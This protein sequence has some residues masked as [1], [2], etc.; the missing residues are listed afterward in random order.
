M[1]KGRRKLC[2]VRWAV[3]S[4]CIKNKWWV[5]QCH[6]TPYF[7]FSSPCSLCCPILGQQFFSL[8]ISW[9]LVW[10][11]LEGVNLGQGVVSRS[12]FGMSPHTLSTSTLFIS[13]IQIHTPTLCCLLL[14]PFLFPILL[15][16]SHPHVCAA[17]PWCCKLPACSIWNCACYKSPELTAPTHPA[18]KH[19]LQ[20]T[21]QLPS[22]THM[23]HFHY[24]LGNS[25]FLTFT[26]KSTMP[27]NSLW[28]IIKIV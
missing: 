4:A 15:T 7:H 19:S 12:I 24:I 25:S 21:L 5:C 8:W 17:C 1:A 16:I 28:Y 23:L 3:G 2:E 22:L 11:I 14:V 20:Q 27:V 6:R 10:G 18:C 13:P 26:F 9:T